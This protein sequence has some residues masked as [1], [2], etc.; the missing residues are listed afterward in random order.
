MSMVDALHWMASHAFSLLADG[1]IPNPDPK[2]PTNGAEGLSLL[3]SYAKWG[4][5]AACGI[6]ALVS[7]GYMGVGS[8]SNRPDS[9]DKGKRA[10]L[11][12]L[13]GVLVTAIA[14]PLTNGVFSAAS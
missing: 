12:S 9:V 1:G 4:A 10:L 14:I 11:W 6:S 3:F 13:G 8:L 5:L 2:D 7:G